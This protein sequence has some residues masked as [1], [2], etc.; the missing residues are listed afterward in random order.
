MAK[1][2]WLAAEKV[3][4]AQL[5]LRKAE[6]GRLGD[7]K[8]AAER[9][10][11]EKKE[12]VRLAAESAEVIERKWLA[13]GNSLVA[14]QAN[15]STPQN[16]MVTPNGPGCT[17]LSERLAAGTAANERL[18][19]EE[20]GPKQLAAETAQSE[21]L[22]VEQAEG[23][24]LA[25]EQVES[26]R[27]A[28]GTAANG[29]AVHSAHRNPVTAESGCRVEFIRSQAVRQQVGV[30]TVQRGCI[31][32]GLSVSEMQQARR[33]THAIVVE[34]LRR[35]LDHR[36]QEKLAAR[37]ASHAIVTERLERTMQQR[38]HAANALGVLSH[39][40]SGSTYVEVRGIDHGDHVQR[41]QFETD[42]TSKQSNDCSGGFHTFLGLLHEDLGP[43]T[44]R[45]GFVELRQLL[46]SPPSNTS[47]VVAVSETRE[48]AHILD[49]DIEA[50]FSDMD[51]GPIAG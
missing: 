19:T 43:V 21:Y 39:Q 35:T 6:L 36:H 7:E 41:S 42:H 50:A 20:A 12:R 10:A 2:E 30:N 15:S 4:E 14:R 16:A 23:K 47:T 40:G 34:R 33:D 13:A 32:H 48:R 45:P 37:R 31:A 49:T 18:D 17:Q 22:A 38:E 1:V 3:R 9:L 28:A 51:D 44:Q 11:A 8:A 25:A 27:L 26:E 5:A 46:Q 24:L 29:L